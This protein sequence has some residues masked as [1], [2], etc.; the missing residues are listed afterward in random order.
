[1]LNNDK[2]N[3][4]K[5]NEFLASPKQQKDMRKN[6]KISEETKNHLD[7]LSYAKE[8]SHSDCIYKLIKEYAETL[9][10]TERVLYETTLKR[11][12]K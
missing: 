3:K 2:N 11:T 12:K 7:A 10:E 8:L 4:R 5:Q 1:M 9:G 6:I